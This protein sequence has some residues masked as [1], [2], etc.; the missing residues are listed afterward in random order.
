ML[1]VFFFRICYVALIDARD[2]YRSPNGR[3]KTF[4]PCRD[5]NFA[6]RLGLFDCKMGREFLLFKADALMGV[7]VLLIFALAL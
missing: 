6:W 3:S 2:F 1:N 7:K 5:L 4:C